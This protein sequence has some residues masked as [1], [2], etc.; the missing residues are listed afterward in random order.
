MSQSI[1]L[2]RRLGS[3][4]LA[5]LGSELVGRVATFGLS[6]Y[7]ANQLGERAF[8][9][10]N[11]GLALGFVLA[12]IADMGL[13][14]L[15]A[16]DVAIAGRGAQPL[17]ARSLRLKV[18]LS[19]P[20]LALLLLLRDGRPAAEQIALLL[21]G[22]AM[23]AQTFLEFAAYV[24]RGQQRVMREAGLLTAAR[25]LTALFAGAA[26]WA[27]AGLP[28]VGAAYL[29]AIAGTALWGMWGLRA[30][31]WF[32]SRSRSGDATSQFGEPPVTSPG[33]R[34][35]MDGLSYGRLI[36]EALPLGIAIFLS[37]G[38]TRVAVFLLEYRLGPLAVAEFS[39]AHRL[40]EPAQIV[41]AALLAAVFPAFSEALHRDPGQARWLGWGS[42]LLLALAG[43]SAALVF[44]FGAPWLIPTLYGEAFVDSVP[45]LQFLGLSALPAFIN[46]NLTHILIARGQQ[47]YS[48][49]FVA[50]MLIL[51]SALTWTFIPVLGAVAPALSV[52]FAEVILLLLCIA[53]LVL[54]RGKAGQWNE[55]EEPRERSHA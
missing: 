53:I 18:W 12:Q 51:H 45:V 28:A 40:V 37:I 11:Y 21:L 50:V 7:I 32:L 17:V 22:L 24:Y 49:I 41:P 34:D 4:A 25:L 15:A 52:T 13:Q 35:S 31:G 39:A 29:L 23:L 44:W 43:G 14:V 33:S 46:Y 5:K 1:S 30:G 47:L 26:I 36:R 6:L 54:T 55:S 2:G 19:L 3:N 8:G 42:S 48:S 9:A 27:G 38:Y 20:V 10:Y 16:R